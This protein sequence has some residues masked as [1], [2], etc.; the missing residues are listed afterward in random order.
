MT[1][2]AIE[3]EGLRK[4]YGDVRALAGIDLYAPTGTVLALLGPNGAGKTTA[5][6][7]LT[8]LLPPTEGLSA[9]PASTSSARRQRSER[10]SGWP[11]STPWWTRVV[12]SLV[13]IAVFG[14]LSVWRYRRA[15]TR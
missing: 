2:A 5:V 13:I 15:V 6:R 1:G 4:S 12:W 8:T 11:A 9:W 14:A 10:E 3:A 7:I